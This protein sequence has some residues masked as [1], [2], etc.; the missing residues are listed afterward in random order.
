MNVF[1][2]WSGVRSKAL[3]EVLSDWLPRVIQVLDPW[4]SPDIEKRKRWSHVMSEQLAG[5]HGRAGR[6]PRRFTADTD[7][8]IYLS[9]ERP[10]GDS[11]LVSS[12]GSA[13]NWDSR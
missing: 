6:R 3:A 10:P 11:P 12:V 7:F 4:V 1:I 13:P 9:K 8:R 2:S 5:P